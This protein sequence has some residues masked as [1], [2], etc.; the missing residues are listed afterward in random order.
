ANSAAEEGKGPH[1]L[2]PFLAV[3]TMVALLWGQG[4]LDWYTGLL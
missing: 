1:P 4:I 3:A 2:G